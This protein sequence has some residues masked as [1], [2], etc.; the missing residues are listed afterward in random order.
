LFLLIHRPMK[1]FEANW[2][3]SRASGWSATP[4]LSKPIA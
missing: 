2:R 4:P 1:L 3:A